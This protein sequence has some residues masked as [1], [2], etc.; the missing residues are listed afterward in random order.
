M[1]AVGMLAPGSTIK[2]WFV[3]MQ[4]LQHMAVHRSAWPLG[5]YSS[6]TVRSPY[7]H[8]SVGSL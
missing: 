6:L 3:H 2:L 8:A 4:H 5:E 7:A 1:Q